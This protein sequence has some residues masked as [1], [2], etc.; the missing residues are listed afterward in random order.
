TIFPSSSTSSEAPSSSSAT[1]SF[2]APIVV[3]PTHAG[4]KSIHPMTTQSKTRSL[5]QREIFN[6]SATTRSSL[7]LISTAQALCDLN[8]CTAMD[9]KISTFISNGTWVLVPPPPHTNIVI[10][11]WLYRHNFDSPGI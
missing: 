9:A 5:K 10:Y 4:P 3:T 8:W 2:V 6:L 11:H 1:T 7:I